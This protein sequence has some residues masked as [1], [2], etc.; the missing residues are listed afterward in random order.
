MNQ[1]G[2]YEQLI[3]QVIENKIDKEKFYVGDRQL[4]TSEAAIWL[5]RFIAKVIAYVIDSIPSGD[6]R[7]HEQI[8]LA[9]KLIFWL[10]DQINDPDFFDEN[11][12]ESK[13]RILTAIFDKK[14]PIAADLDK[15]TKDI[16][17]LTGLTQSELFSGSNAGISLESELK[18]EIASSDEIY[19]LVSFIKWAGIRIFKKELEDFTRSGKKLKIITTSYMGATDAKAIEFLA[20]LPNTEVK[21]S[22]NTQ[23][24]R[25]HAKSYLFIR[26]TGFNTGYIGSSNLSQSALTTGLEWNLKITSQEIPH[27][28][29]K[30]LSTFKTYWQSNDFETFTGEIESKNKLINALSEARGGDGQVN[31]FH[32][33]IKPFNHQKEILELLDCER[34]LHHR[35]RNLVVAA[36]GTGKTIISAFDF[37]RFFKKNPQARFLFIAHRQEI[38]DQARNAY[39]GILKNNSFGE[40]WVGNFRPNKYDHL[41]ASIQTLNSQ[42]ELLDLT[43]DYYDYIVID[44]VHHIAA[45]SYRGILKKFEP[46]ILL[47]LTATPERHDGQNILDD[48][49]GVIAAEIRLPEAINRRHLCPFQYFGL[50]DDTDLSKVGWK[51]G[52][53]DPVELTNLY[54][55]S[56]QRIK[57]I[58]QSINEIITD[59]FSMRALAFCVSKEHAE[60]MT[61][62]FLLNGIPC[63]YL[64]SDNSDERLVKRQKLCTGE[65]KI[66]CVVDIFNEG[67]DIPEIDTLLFLRPTESL[68][69]FLQQLGRGLRLSDE[70]QCC[71]VLDFVGNARPEY[72]FSQKFRAL[73]GKTNQSIESEVSNGFPHL[74]LGCRIELQE[75]TQS[76]ILQNIRRAVLNKQRLISLIQNFHNQSN[77][78]LNIRNFLTINSNIE[79][80]DIYNIKLPDLSGWTSLLDLANDNDKIDV[81]E[82]AVYSAYYRAI[83]NHLL[84][85]T[86]ISYLQFVRK[87]SANDFIFNSDD[88][89]E[90]RYALMCHYNFWGKSGK[91]LNYSSLSESLSKLKHPQLQ[92]ELNAVLDILIDRIHDNELSNENSAIKVH[93]RYTRE[94]ILAGYGASSFEKSSPSREGVLSLESKN[95]ELLFVTLNKNEKQFSPTTM[96]HDFALSDLLFH[97]Q[98]QN[99]AKPDKGKGLS[100]VNHQANGLKII[101]FVREQSKDEN[102]RT[103]GFVNFGPVKYLSHQGSQPM[104]ITWELEYPMPANMWHEAA[105]LAMP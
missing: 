8:I 58:I 41:F 11:L 7:L 78:P 23:H 30:S 98:S 51:N 89:I 76:M 52:K 62:K 63:D 53:Y 84:A 39:R 99:S 26:K 75:K 29:E 73:V 15:Y 83:N 50:D 20:G 33:D 104:N 65:I 64:T 54:T 32:F 102:G 57:R 60:Y 12:I 27:I 79:L 67:I 59:V 6:N 87:L 55:H 3:T 80:E 91:E 100:Y 56:E 69:I 70:K 97:W 4:D 93:A 35:F 1:I 95:T 13:G 28:I 25:L 48:F 96:Y 17:P 86:S 94:Q 77:L 24:E 37:A 21:L 2:I 16:F 49:C 10:K 81:A 31:S 85:C 46:K 90:S 14:N 40:L 92:D 43:K 45:H 71:T 18:R 42:L 74:P 5:S 66:L 47:G 61:K 103:M 82:R 88:F 19:W 72:D 44:E 38:L 101:L 34:N 9:N 105:K 68:T 22:Y 36:T